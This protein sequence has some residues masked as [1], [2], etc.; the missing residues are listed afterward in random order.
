MNAEEIK[1]EIVDMLRKNNGESTCIQVIAKPFGNHMPAIKQ[2]LIELEDERR[3]RK[4]HG[5]RK[6]RYY[7]PT[8]AQIEA[9]ERCNQARA[10]PAPLKVERRRI[11]LYAE[12]ERARNAIPSLNGGA[13]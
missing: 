1:N 8:K 11:E 7:I 10:M 4:V 9:E 6:A 2:I 3:I 13:S 12:L 5:E